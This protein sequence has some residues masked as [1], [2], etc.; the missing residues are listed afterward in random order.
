MDQNSLIEC[1][2]DKISSAVKTSADKIS[3]AEIEEEDDDENNRQRF[4]FL[5]F[6]RFL[7]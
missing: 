6:S 4:I 2:N 5:Q 3:S 7:S 1:S